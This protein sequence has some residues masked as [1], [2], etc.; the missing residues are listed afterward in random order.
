MLNL[1]LPAPVVRPAVLQP[2]WPPVLVA[3]VEE[4]EEGEA[5]AEAEV[6]V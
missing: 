2:Y 3:P 4:E 1:A 5:E 6:D